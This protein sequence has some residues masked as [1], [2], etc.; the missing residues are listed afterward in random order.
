MIAEVSDSQ[1]G[2]VTSAQARARGVTH[3]NLVRLEQ[4][5]DLIRVAHG[6]YRDAGAP[7][8]E[9]EQIRAAWLAADPTKLAHER[10]DDDPISAVVSGRSAAELHG[11]GDLPAD[12]HELTTPTRRQ[13]QRDDLRYRIRLLPSQDI[14]VRD[15]LA[16]TTRERTIADLVEEREDL[17]LV[18]DVL[19]DAARQSALDTGRLVVLLS[20]LAAR[21][22]HPKGD[23]DSLLRH[24]LDIAGLGV[25]D[26]VR[27]VTSVPAVGLGVLKTRIDHIAET[28]PQMDAGVTAHLGRSL[29][30]YISPEESTA[31][32]LNVASALAQFQPTLDITRQLTPQ[33][34]ATTIGQLPLSTS[35][36]STSSQPDWTALVAA[37]TK[38]DAS[39]DEDDT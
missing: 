37:L 3:M 34:L 10:L 25:D 36:I 24:L 8:D 15:G 13:T 19:R 32:I 16:L 39:D 28:V 22:G 9:H 6:V 11:I 23:G 29:T 26:L 12:V 1:W 27:T 17:S 35:V 2:M 33:G 20:P 18:A 21:N 31:W 4:S 38:P 30:D 5:G 7:A 14:T